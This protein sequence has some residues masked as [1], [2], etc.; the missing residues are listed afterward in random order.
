M[1]SA[2]TART[3]PADE[4]SDGDGSEIHEDGAGSR[5]SGSFEEGAESEVG[6]EEAQAMGERERLV[7]WWCRKQLSRCLKKLRGFPEAGPFLEPLPW[8]ELAL[9][10]TWRSSKI[11]WI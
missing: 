9:T 6:S 2:A 8:K 4:P 3:Q 11:L 7:H 1:A 5:A 10:T